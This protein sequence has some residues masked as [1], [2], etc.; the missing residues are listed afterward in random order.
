MLALFFQGVADLGEELHFLGGLGIGRGLG[1]GLLL[2]PAELVHALDHE[3]DHQG[4]EQEA[5]DVLDEVAVLEGGLL[6]AGGLVGSPQDHLQRGEVDAAEEQADDGHEHVVHERADDGGEG[7]A[8]D[9][10]HGHI[11]YVATGDEFF[12]FS[13]DAFFLHCFFLL[14]KEYIV[15]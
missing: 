10:A 7:A 15:V 8:H 2:L 14:A 4:D 9:D 5:D 6:D 11:H 13:Y 12:E 1:G 3:E